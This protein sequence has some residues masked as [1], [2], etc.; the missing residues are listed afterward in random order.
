MKLK[1]VSDGTMQGTRIVDEATG[2][3]IENVVSVEIRIDARTR[4]STL[5]LELEY[6]E[7]NVVTGEF[8]RKFMEGVW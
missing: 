3:A 7:I 2:E 4:L 6:P 1:V 8:E 5:V